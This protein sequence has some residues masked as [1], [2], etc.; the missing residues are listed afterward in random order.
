M[1][2]NNKKTITICSVAAL[3]ILAIVVVVTMINGL[4][5]FSIVFGA[6][7]VVLVICLAIYLREEPDE[8]N[9][10]IRNKK[11]ILRTYDSIIIEVED[12]PNI[13]GKN[14][15]KVKTIEDL[16]DA[17][18][19][20]REPIYYKNDN[21]SCFFILLHFNEACIFVLRMNDSVV[22]PT[23]QSIRYMKEEKTDKTKEQENILEN[24]EKTVVYKLDELRS[25]RISPIRNN[26]KINVVD[27]T[28]IKKEIESSKEQEITASALSSE[29]SKT[30]YLKDLRERML[31]YEEEQISK[32][33]EIATTQAQ[34]EKKLEEKADESSKEVESEVEE[35][36][37]E[38]S[39]I[40]KLRMMVKEQEQEITRE[41]KLEEEPKDEIEPAS[42]LREVASKVEQEEL[43]ESQEVKEEKEEIVEHSNDIDGNDTGSIID[44]P[45]KKEIKLEIVEDTGKANLSRH[46]DDEDRITSGTHIVTIGDDYDKK[47]DNDDEEFVTGVVVLHSLDEDEHFEP[48][49]VDDNDKGFVPVTLSDEED[50][51][52]EEE[53]DI[54]DKFKPVSLNSDEDEYEDEVEIEEPIEIE[55]EKIEEVIEEKVEEEPEEVNE[56]E[57]EAEIEEENEETESDKK[58]GSDSN[59]PRRNVKPKKATHSARRAQKHVSRS[60]R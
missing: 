30:M 60:K 58:V 35:V 10:Y 52:E 43:R 26:E 32:T 3:V 5:G 48:V 21:D 53:M 47:E 13:A 6:F 1:N 7:F 29:L 55:E 54:T 16:V 57:E 37:E 17:Q 49:K 27:D 34:L 15:I 4:T 18:L 20:L 24:L 12:I 33:K 50:D 42:L 19:E 51:D 22:S 31:K 44:E 40:E 28:A 25:F 45:V 36:T 39:P 23:E 46:R 11:K 59:K 9:A 2:N 41:L 56:T 8:F 14:I 38:L